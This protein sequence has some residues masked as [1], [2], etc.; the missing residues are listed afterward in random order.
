MPEV[1]VMNKN[2]KPGA[3]VC[4]VLIFVF[5]MGLYPPAILAAG[6]NPSEETVE[7]ITPSELYA[8]CAVLMDADSGRILFSKNGREEA[9]MAS[10]T[11]IMTCI[12]ALENGDPKDRVTASAD[13]AAQPEVKLGM[14][15]KVTPT[16][17]GRVIS[18]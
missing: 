5:V 17:S 10:T 16:G 18:D 4:L 1:S 14:R 12:L 15:E 2:L 3:F 7:E 11:K 9:P 8:R 6:E 13:A